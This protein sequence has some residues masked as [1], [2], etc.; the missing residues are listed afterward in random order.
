MDTPIA[1]NATPA[2]PYDFTGL[3]D[4][5]FTVDEVK[6][7]ITQTNAT[8]YERGKKEVHDQVRPIIQKFVNYCVSTMP[9]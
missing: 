1:D 8:E 7:I 2:A 3:D 6:A 5:L 4:K 9:E